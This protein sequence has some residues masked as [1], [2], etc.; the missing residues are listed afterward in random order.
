[1]SAM[2]QISADPDVVARRAMG[3]L[4]F[5]D[6]ATGLSI[7]DGLMAIARVRNKAIPAIPSPSGVYI[8]HQLPG[9]SMVSFWDGVMEPKP[10]PQS[11]EFKI[12]VRDLSR[13]FFPTSFKSSFTAWPEAPIICTGAGT[14]DNKIPLFSA[15][16]RLPRNDFAIIR[17]TLR[18]LSDDKPAAWALLRVFRKDDDVTTDKPV[19]EG[20]AGPDGEFMLLF[21][22]PKADL[23]ALNGAKGPHWTMRIKAWYDSPDAQI[24]ANELPDGENRL[25]ELCSILKQQSA[26]LLAEIGPDVELTPQEMTPDQTLQLKTLGKKV[27]YLK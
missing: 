4:R 14:L 3:V 20:V 18:V 19:I 17:G 27:L 21:P 8:F 16:W 6:A 9:L 2:P 10:E 26:T 7:T 25:P 5:V 23:P 24:P 11:Y 12:E 15:S 22:W 1:M 13:R